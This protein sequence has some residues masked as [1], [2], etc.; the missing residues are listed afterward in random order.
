MHHSTLG[1]RGITKK[2]EGAHPQDRR[3]ATARDWISAGGG[4][5]TRGAAATFSGTGS[6]KEKC[7]CGREQLGAIMLSFLYPYTSILG[8][9]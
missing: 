9:I 1:L 2:E 3:I 6:P 5:S 4:S 7:V 8:D